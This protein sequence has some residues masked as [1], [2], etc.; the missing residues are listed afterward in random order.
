MEEEQW[1]KTKEE[2]GGEKE[3]R[4]DRARSCW[5]ERRLSISSSSLS[6]N[7]SPLSTS[8]SLRTIYMSGSSLLGMATASAAAI[9]D[10]LPLS[11]ILRDCSSRFVA[12]TRCR[13][14]S[15]Y[16]GTTCSVSACSA[17][18]CSVSASASEGRGR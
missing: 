2:K 4:K 13:R 10:D 11:L 12:A 9:F 6:T 15:T 17:S 14:L 16:L 7:F 18:A 8:L 3:K 5:R 1:R